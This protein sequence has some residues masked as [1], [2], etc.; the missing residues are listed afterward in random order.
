MQIIT[1]K[2]DG[3]A[4]GVWVSFGENGTDD[5]ENGWDA[6]KLM[7]GENSPQLY[8]TQLDRKLSINH[9]ATLEENE[10]IVSMSFMA[11][12]DGEQHIIANLENIPNTDI[13]IEDKQTGKF[14]DLVKNPEYTFTASVDDNP[15]R[16]NLHFKSK[17][18]GIEP[19][20]LSNEVNVYSN[21]KNIYII[22]EGDALNYSGSV[23]VV[24]TFGRTILKQQLDKS[25]RII[26]PV[27]TESGC[28][29]VRVIKGN[30]INT[31]KIFI[32]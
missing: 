13:S 23:E 11:G 26:I 18:F 32:N 10:R 1:A 7:G 6:S 8:L 16:F 5:F 25:D 31:K 9:L 28:F 29:I 24:D 27:S 4:D 19:N 14:H 17:T 20:F 15:D 12:T 30:V 3:N 2:K 21:A 22:S